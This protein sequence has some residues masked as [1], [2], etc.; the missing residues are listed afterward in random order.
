M[1]MRIATP[2]AR[3]RTTGPGTPATETPVPTRGGF[4][5]LELLVVLS[6]VGMSAALAVP[7]LYRTYQNL[8]AGAEERRLGEMAAATS[9]SAFCRQQDRTLH[10]ADR[11]VRDQEQAV[12]EHFRFLTFPRQTIHWNANG[13]PDA[14]KLRYAIRGTPREMPLY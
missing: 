13:F 14:R 3:A 9:L 2:R 12:L 1:A 6:I 10:L 8:Q 5:L 11:T 7:P 4:T